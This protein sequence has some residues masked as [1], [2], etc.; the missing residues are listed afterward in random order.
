MEIREANESDIPRIVEL[1]RASLGE[2]LMPKSVEYWRWKHIN[3]PFGPSPVLLALE[4]DAVIGVRAFMRW[5]WRN[6][7]ITI[8]AVRAVDTATHP[9]HQGKG[10]FRKLTMALLDVC[11]QRGLHLV[12]NTPNEKSLPG[13]LKMGWQKTGNLPVQLRLPTPGALGRRLVNALPSVD[14]WD[15]GDS[16]TNAISLISERGILQKST[17]ANGAIIT[18]Y[19]SEYL[20]WRYLD[21]PVVKYMAQSIDTKHGGAALFFRLKKSSLGVECRITDCV[22]ET[23]KLIPTVQKQI[24]QLAK[25]T[26][27]T[28]VTI[29]G[30]QSKSLLGNWSVKISGGPIVTTREISTDAVEKFRNFAVWTP[31]LGDLELF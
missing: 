18:D 19:S 25:E 12:F 13:Y 29:D 27:A 8:R 31:S 10:I 15:G 5:D 24:R 26:R 16:I 20:R 30:L 6:D 17:H 4:N 21:V 1:L 7:D 3:N 28:Y 11:K 14:T 2:S 22:L 9:D 23:P